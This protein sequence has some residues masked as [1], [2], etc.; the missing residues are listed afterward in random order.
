MAPNSNES[1]SSDDWLD[2]LL[3][4]TFGAES[5]AE[6]PVAAE[7]LGLEGVLAVATDAAP[8]QDASDDEPWPA[9]EAGSRY[10]VLEVA[11]RGGLGIVYRG[12]DH[13]LG[14]EV[15]LKTLDH[16]LAADP[17][18]VRRFIDEAQVCGRLQHPGVVPV[19]E[20]GLDQHERPF[21]V[22][23]LIRGQT[24]AEV[25]AARGTVA[26]DRRRCLDAFEKVCQTVGYAHQR[27]VVHRD[28]KP[29]NVM[30]G[31]FG[32]VQVVDWGLALVL[33]EPQ[34]GAGDLPGTLSVPST[35][36]AETVAGT[37]TGTPGYMPPEQAR[38]ETGRI[39]ARS[40]VFALGAMLSEILTGVPVHA[41]ELAKRTQIERT[42]RGELEAVQQ[43]LQECGAERDLVALAHSCLA[44]A[45]EDRPASAAVIA[46]ALGEHLASLEERSRQA[47]LRAVAA[48][49]KARAT[50]MVASMAVAVLVVGSGAIIWWRE[51]NHR[52]EVTAVAQVDAATEDAARLLERARADEGVALG[53]WD[54]AR[55]AA[56]QAV[57]LAA[58]LPVPGSIRERVRDLESDVERERA[59]ALLRVDQRRRDQKM[60][61][62]LVRARAPRA[63]SAEYGRHWGVAQRYRELFA[64]YLIGT[65]LLSLA[66]DDAVDALR[67]SVEPELA[68]GLDLWSLAL[69]RSSDV[70]HLKRTRSL[71]LWSLALAPWCAPHQ[72]SARLQAIARRL[73]AGDALRNQLRDLI[74]SRDGLELARVVDEVDLTTVSV[75]SLVLLAELCVRSSTVEHGKAVY[76]RAC[77]LH[78]S[79]VGATIGAAMLDLDTNSFE[80]ALGH[81]RIARALDPD[82]AE[83]R[84]R[85]G[86]CLDRLGRLDEATQCLQEAL[87]VHP[88]SGYIALLLWQ[89]LSKLGR[90]AEAAAVL[91][92]F[93][94]AAASEIAASP[95][96]L[97]LRIDLARAI[98][99]QQR[100]EDGIEVL[101]AV[102]AANARSKSLTWE[103]F[104]AYS[105]LGEASRAVG[106]FA[107]AVN[108]LKQSLRL[109]P[110]D[111]ITNSIMGLALWEA[112]DIE[113]CL[114]FAQRGVTFGP[115][116]S[117][118]QATLG[119]LLVQLGRPEEAVAHLERAIALNPAHPDAR[120]SLGVALVALA[121]PAEAIEHLETAV[122]S[123][124]RVNWVCEALNRLAW[125]IVDPEVE[126]E[127]RDLALALRAAEKVV[128][129]THGQNGSVLDTLARVFAWQGELARAIEVQS[130]AVELQREVVARLERL[131][132]EAGSPPSEEAKA[133]KQLHEWV[134]GQVE[135]TLEEYKRKAER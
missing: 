41:H 36:R 14:R 107:E 96:N 55:R 88:T 103:L 125:T 31:A 50:S 129:L 122:A 127:T 58:A 62:D 21:F 98:L 93:E 23:K 20:L 59:A 132:R 76:R 130:R 71:G 34:G 16:R 115:D 13:D 87:A 135:R 99:A 68:M 85:M 131:E 22:M 32:E 47:Q 6:A 63:G 97:G 44:P 48:R 100:A 79:D 61:Q 51:G 75:S 114:T 37:A 126:L 123:D 110:N 90:H 94:S 54:E 30:I 57:L 28:L 17:S 92:R 104:A 1:P 84:A 124:F 7:V 133:T 134:L 111:G 117:E 8:V 69:T 78:P 11:A 42:A 105:L 121:R 109:N 15:A 102:L 86:Q 40:D 19:H 118:T 52:R 10:E 89:F 3:Q 91:E 27:G 35:R 67:S 108:W 73:D 4:Q 43:R 5:V 29:G 2:H 39:D 33:D 12:H 74:A 53:A 106:Q 119:Y 120:L 95:A 64:S 128:A 116:D 26:D 65:D 49:A 18:F 38:G 101:R 81:F 60:A 66:T 77:E 82:N 83:I 46:K 70:R 80:S 25:L 24:F 56:H 72:A 45:M 113:E 9:L 112:G